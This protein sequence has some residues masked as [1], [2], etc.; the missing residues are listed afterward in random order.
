MKRFIVG[1]IT[2][3]VLFAAIE[4]VRDSHFQDDFTKIVQTAIPALSALAKLSGKSSAE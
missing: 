1:V 4:T 2:A 3:T